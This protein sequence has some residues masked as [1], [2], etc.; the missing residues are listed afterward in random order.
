[1]KNN[2]DQVPMGLRPRPRT[3]APGVRVDVI[4]LRPD[5]SHKTFA[6]IDYTPEQ[7]LAV[8][9]GFVRSMGK[10]MPVVLLE[11]EPDVKCSHTSKFGDES[12]LKW[13]CADC[14]EDVS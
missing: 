2:I 1:M 7:A 8:A 9:T 3:D 6:Q 11:P 10:Q 4:E 5:G 12:L 13:R 14:G